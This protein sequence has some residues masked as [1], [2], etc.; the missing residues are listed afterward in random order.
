[1]GEGFPLYSSSDIRTK[2]EDL[3]KVLADNY[4]DD[5]ILFNHSCDLFFGDF[6]L[7]LV[8]SEQAFYIIENKKTGVV[9][10]TSVNSFDVQILPCF[11]SSKLATSYIKTLNAE[12]EDFIVS[13][14]ATQEFLR[15]LKACVLHRVFFINLNAGDADPFKRFDITIPVSAIYS[16][17]ATS[18]NEICEKELIVLDENVF[19]Y[20]LFLT[21]LSRNASCRLSCVSDGKNPYFSSEKKARIIR[22][23]DDVNANDLAALWPVS[24]EMLFFFDRPIDLYLGSDFPIWTI[25][26]ILLRKATMFFCEFP[27]PTSFTIPVNYE[28]NECFSQL[29]VSDIQEVSDLSITS[30]PKTNLKEEDKCLSFDEN[31]RSATKENAGGFSSGNFS[32]GVD[33][34]VFNFDD[35]SGGV[36][37]K[38]VEN[39]PVKEK[40]GFLSFFKRDDSPSEERIEDAVKKKLPKNRLIAIIAFTFS[41]FLLLLFLIS[42][43]ISSRSNFKLFESKLENRKYQSA[44]EL[45]EKSKVNDKWDN[46]LT[47]SIDTLSDL[48]AKNEISQSVVYDYMAILPNFPNQQEPISNELEEISRIDA[49]R[50]RYNEGKNMSSRPADVLLAWSTI[51][52]VDEFSYHTART[53]ANENHDGWISEVS[54]KIASLAKAGDYDTAKRYLSAALVFY[55]DDTTLLNL[56]SEIDTLVVTK[57]SAPISIKS[58]LSRIEPGNDLSL[59]IQWE[60]LSNKTILCVDFYFIFLDK[61]GDVVAGEKNGEKCYVFMG[62]EEPGTYKAGYVTSSDAHGWTHVWSGHAEQVATV[63]ALKAIVSYPDGSTEQVVFDKSYDYYLSI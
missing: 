48:Y 46:A 55:P 3:S 36:D 23:V 35:E 62:R 43:P 29:A 37:D 42:G 6:F 5:K 20:L 56:S 47:D 40:K 51:E 16:R 4:Y 53:I 19:D 59:L 7:D 60:N 31:L 13:S 38:Y 45:Y 26:P 57:A 32:P 44:L 33:S 8:R 9:Y 14:Y 39:E 18:I 25:D 58:L 63:K 27:E 61:N 52:Q 28:N 54:Y 24:Y 49:S 11:T 34:P 10:S 50:E 2:I 17:I 21:V 41:G 12:S 15:V 30:A 22:N 1:M